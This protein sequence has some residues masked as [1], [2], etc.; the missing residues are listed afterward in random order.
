[1]A[2]RV[3][4]AKLLG[5]AEVHALGLT[6]KQRPELG[7]FGLRVNLS[8]KQ[9]RSFERHG[10]RQA[11]RFPVYP[12]PSGVMLAVPTLQVDNLQVRIAVPLFDDKAC[13]WANWCVRAQRVRWLVDIEEVNQTALVDLQ[14]DFPEPR[15]VLELIER[16]Q[17]D[18]DMEALARDMVSAVAALAGDDAIPSCVGGMQVRDVK[19]G[20]VGDFAEHFAAREV[21]ERHAGPAVGSTVH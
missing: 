15:V 21:L 3:G 13:S 11:L 10:A 8:D 17:R 1:M 7:G 14:Q 20:V 18:A 16:S 4:G 5:P 9:L 2:Q 12:L 6:L 19:L